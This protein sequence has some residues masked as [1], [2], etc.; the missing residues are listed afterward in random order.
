M[1]ILLKKRTHH[2]VPRCVRSVADALGL[3]P[4]QRDGRTVQ[5]ETAVRAELVAVTLIWAAFSPQA[6]SSSALPTFKE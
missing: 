5:R 1:K 2:C 4:E 6:Q 3:S